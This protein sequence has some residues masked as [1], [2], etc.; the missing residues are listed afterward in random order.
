MQSLIADELNFRLSPVAVIFT[1]EKPAG[2]LQFE[3]GQRGCLIPM[4]VAATEGKT[5][6]FDRDTVPCPGGR[7]GL[8]FSGGYRDPEEMAYFLSTPSG[9]PHGW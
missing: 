7:V 2:A 1:D 3:P 9:I 8:E 5:A 6:A 4:L